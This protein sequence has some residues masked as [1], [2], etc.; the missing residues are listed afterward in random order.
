[1]DQTTNVL[2]FHG[3]LELQTT[4]DM[5]KKVVDK[6]YDLKTDLLLYHYPQLG[7]LLWDGKNDQLRIKYLKAKTMT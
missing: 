6:G 2:Q 5:Q 7:K 1:M 4:N 3:S